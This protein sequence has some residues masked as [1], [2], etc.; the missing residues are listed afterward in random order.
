MAANHRDWKKL[1]I[2][3]ARKAWGDKFDYSKV[4]F[5]SPDKKVTIICPIHG[6]FRQAS[7]VH[8][9]IGCTECNKIARR[10]REGNTTENFIKRHKEKYGDFYDYSKTVFVDFE[11]PMTVI[12]PI[13][14]E[15][16]PMPAQFTE[17]R[18]KKCALDAAGKKRRLTT[19]QV[20]SKFRAK[21]GDKYDYSR[22]NYVSRSAKLEVVCPKHGSIFRN[23]STFLRGGC[24]KC[25]KEERDNEKSIRITQKLIADHKKRY[26]DFYDYSK[27]VFVNNNTYMTVICPIHGEFKQLPSNFT[28]Y[29]CSKC[30]MERQ[31]KAR[32]G[33]KEDFIAR[34]T[35]IHNG[36]YDYSKVEY[37]NAKTD[38]TIICPVHGPFK[39]TPDIH[40]HGGGCKR[41]K[42]HNKMPQIIKN[43][44]WYVDA[45]RLTKDE[46]IQKANKVHGVGTYDYR[47]VS[48]TKQ[49]DIVTIYC[50][51][52]GK[53]RQRVSHHLQGYGC[54]KCNQS[55]GERAIQLY[56]DETGVNYSIQKTFEDCKYKQEL[57]FDFAIYNSDG[58]LRCLI[59]Y[60]GQQHFT[61]IQW[62][63][64]KFGDYENQIIRDEIKRKYCEDNGIQLLYCSYAQDL[65]EF[66]DEAGGLL[67]P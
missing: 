33:T 49:S 2:E 65:S 19:E 15:F 38:V 6:E 35:K 10:E 55:K 31:I 42:I 9:R 13:H 22:V 17:T 46:F 45:T 12:C 47:D 54:Q 14:G 7:K 25:A 37:V 43:R 29:G 1:F 27:T 59:E 41:C 5:G 30:G 60:Q 53:F 51:K 48:F 3:R 61:N 39:Q 34:S 11:T 8:A 24:T 64:V 20:I 26:G 58:T 50:K 56:L 52:H 40:V 21:F 23:F 36:Y 67:W 44:Q 62:K 28:R 4:E 63:G 66:F 16:H 57:R 32:T 18:C